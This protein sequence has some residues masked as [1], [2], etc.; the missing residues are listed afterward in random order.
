MSVTTLLCLP[1]N[2]AN[3]TLRDI[4]THEVLYTV[5]SESTG[6]NPVTTIKN[7]LGSVI[8]TSEWRDAVRGHKLTLG[9]EN[10]GVSMPART[11]LKKSMIPFKDTVT[12]E[13]T[14]GRKFKWK[15][16][17]PGLALELYGS[18]DKT[19]PIARFQKSAKDYTS[20]PPSITPAKLLIDSRGMEICDLIVISFLMLEKDRR[21]SENEVVGRSRALAFGGGAFS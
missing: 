15:G 6:K 16:N 3:C 7:A 11:W 14:N 13:D 12:F 8:A 1:D 20:N 18:D 17:A 21:L 9:S 4:D 19:R 2:P 10:G 5:T